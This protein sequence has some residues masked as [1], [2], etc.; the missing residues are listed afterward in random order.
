MRAQ[1]AA[2]REPS[3]QAQLAVSKAA[4]R[5]TRPQSSP[6][7]PTPAAPPRSPRVPAKEPP[8]PPPL[9]DFLA[10]RV[11]LLASQPP[12]EAMKLSPRLMPYRPTSAQP[13]A[14]PRV[15]DERQLMPPTL[16]STPI[17]DTPAV[18]VSAEGDTSK[19][20]YGGSLAAARR[21]SADA[22]G[23]EK[24][25]AEARQ[26][27][28]SDVASGTAITSAQPT[29]RSHA[30]MACIGWGEARRVALFGGVEP[31]GKL[32]PGVLHL[33]D[34]LNL[35]WSTPPVRGRGPTQRGGATASALGACRTLFFGG[36]SHN[37]GEA[38]AFLLHMRVAQRRLPGRKVT[39]ALTH[40]HPHSP[41]LTHTHPHS[42]YPP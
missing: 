20:K 33:F 41:T 15:Q 38:D 14:S 25:L 8:A 26:R 36:L 27:A 42:P 11:T 17:K 13:T 22:I 24:H 2:K 18:A 4:Q 3:D 9:P 23:S 31:H 29:A 12:A 1:V 19:G 21:M 10:S 30:A 32:A 7:K 35:L 40:T 34:P 37:G 39:M 28:D 16:V 6:G 5:A